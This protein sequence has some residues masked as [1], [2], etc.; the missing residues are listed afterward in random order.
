MS[1]NIPHSQ[2]ELFFESDN[3]GRGLST[4]GDLDSSILNDLET[5]EDVVASEEAV[6]ELKNSPETILEIARSYVGVN[7]EE[8]A[9]SIVTTESVIDDLAGCEVGVDALANAEEAMPTVAADEDA[10]GAFAD[11]NCAMDA[12]TSSEIASEAMAS[13]IVSSEAVAESEIAMARVAENEPAY[14]QF[15]AQSTAMSVFADS[16]TALEHIV[17]SEEAITAAA[18]AEAGQDELTDTEL[19]LEHIT[20]DETAVDA[21]FAN[22]DA[23]EQLLGADYYVGQA[24]GTYDDE[25]PE[26]LYATHDTIEE[27]VDDLD[28]VGDMAEREDVMNRIGVSP[29]AWAAVEDDNSAMERVAEGTA[30][31]RGLMSTRQGRDHFFGADSHVGTGMATYDENLDEEEFD[32]QST[33][34]N[35]ANNSGAMDDLVTSQKSIDVVTGSEVA[36]EELAQSSSGMSSVFG[37]DN[38]TDAFFGSSW[39][40]GTGMET[41]DGTLDDEV[42]SEL[43]T[44]EDVVND[45]DAMDGIAPSADTVNRIAAS[46]NAMD[47]LTDSRIGMQEV[48]GR[49]SAMDEMF[50]AEVGRDMFFEGVAGVGQGM[51]TYDGDLG[52][53]VFER[54][55]SMYDVAHSRSALSDIVGSDN[56]I[57]N[58]IADSTGAM[59]VIA[60]TE[61]AMSV[62][63][64]EEESMEVLTDYEKAM[65]AIMSDNIGSRYFFNA[66]VYV[67][68]GMATYD[69]LLDEDLFDDFDK[70]ADV[71]ENEDALR[72]ATGSAITMNSITSSPDAMETLLVTEEGR[73]SFYRSN[74]LVGI[75]MSTH[76]DSLERVDF[77]D[78]PTLG[79]VVGDEEAIEQAADSQK[80]MRPISESEPAMETL[81]DDETAREVVSQSDV[82][83]SEIMNVDMATEEWFNADSWVGRGLATYDNTLGMDLF[84]QFDTYH[85]II[86]D[87]QTASNLVLS[88][89][90]M[91][92][93]VWSRDLLYDAFNEETIFDVLIEAR[94]SL[95]EIG[96]S[97]RAMK[98]TD[99]HEDA[100]EAFTDRTMPTAKLIAVA[101]DDL[102]PEDWDDTEDVREEIDFSDEDDIEDL[103]QYWV[104][105]CGVAKQLGEEMLDDN[106]FWGL[107]ETD[108]VGTQMLWT[109]QKIWEYDEFSHDIERLMYDHDAGGQISEERSDG[110]DGSE[111]YWTKGSDPYGIVSETFDDE[112]WA[113]DSIGTPYS[114]GR[115]DEKV[116]ISVR[117]DNSGDDYHL[118]TWQPVDVTDWD[119]LRFMFA[120]TG[121]NQQVNLAD[122]ITDGGGSGGSNMPGEE[123]YGN[124]SSESWKE[125]VVDISEFEGEKH[126]VFNA[127]GSSNAAVGYSG[128][129]LLNNKEDE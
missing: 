109:N 83:M 2:R 91:N 36:M 12:F 46:E 107:A 126:I 51:A 39:H 34:S 76:D 7:H 122:D 43:D 100:R 110:E 77:E 84:S 42:M 119:E 30:G 45:P 97:E 72:E 50:E 82:A 21:F 28:A 106:D 101:M 54:L 73:D 3:V 47:A 29:S 112:S 41:Y 90:I 118:G 127:T 121:H 89:T 35:V 1:E 32:G 65:N 79:D 68:R 40:V 9:E 70:F 78:K 52:L 38:A 93:V 129:Q 33:F 14:T 108:P 74:F 15:A 62:L 124:N 114:E 25:I 16:E 26:S 87:A 31:M 116:A 111:K 69:K 128:F 61:T 24:I 94:A 86:K 80:S 48:A 23:T 18:E 88:E 56:D 98:W 63:A 95:N 4:F 22:D 64:T 59:D 57:K 10:M 5:I 120:N 60:R 8:I 75:G 66:D 27:I 55:D 58:I 125:V 81:V 17:E 44:I 113:D 102:D 117:Y 71:T 6:D 67:G 49:G 96:R 105:M 103:I 19:A 53:N 37:N 20:T 123:V 104:S 92:R 99:G 85:D 115:G 11:S 13:E